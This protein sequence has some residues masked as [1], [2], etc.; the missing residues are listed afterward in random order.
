MSEGPEPLVQNTQ[1]PGNNT[2][3][4]FPPSFDGEQG[5]SLE[6]CEAF[7]PAPDNAQAAK[8]LPDERGF[9]ESLRVRVL[10]LR[11]QSSARA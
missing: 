1:W 3:Y 4:A 2:S 11:N 9:P 8:K 5:P 10:V 7:T 6:R